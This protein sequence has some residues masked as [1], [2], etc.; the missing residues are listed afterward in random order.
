[1]KPIKFPFRISP[2]TPFHIGNGTEYDPL[3]LIIKDKVAYFINQIEY[4]RFLLAKDKK[5]LERQLEGSNIKQIHKF[6][7]AAFDPEAKDTYF[8]SYPVK[9]D[10]YETYIKRMDNIQSQGFV[11]A[12]IRSTL[13]MQPYI[14]GSSIKG[15]IRT[16]VLSNLCSDKNKILQDR[17]TDKADRKTQAI[18]L[19]YWNRERNTADIPSDP[20][21]FVKFE[22]IPWKNEWIRIFLVEITTPPEAAGI[23]KNPFQGGYQTK[24]SK[25]EPKIPILME[26]A[27]SRNEWVVDSELTVLV[28]DKYNSGLKKILPS[29][30]NDIKPLLKIVNDYYKKQIDKES[31]YY[32]SMNPSAQKNYE[33]IKGLFQS[34]KDNECIIKLGMGTGQNYCSYAVMNYQPK[35]RKMVNNLPMGWMR[36][37]F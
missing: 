37:T 9:N 23:R 29:G 21:K 28:M 31:E 26:V 16:A 3:T 32:K 27:L 24:E 17:D 36:L 5:A 13:N 33:T 12:F 1:M 10:V 7:S 14:P 30:P 8:F 19:E 15:A 4:I 2:I 34:L 11:Q 35:S 25:R 18:L 20:F 6:F 22:D